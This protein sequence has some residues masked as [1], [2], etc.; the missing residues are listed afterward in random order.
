MG[1]IVLKIDFVVINKIELLI[2]YLNEN[3]L[4]LISNNMISSY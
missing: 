2:I 3:I 1:G 4:Y